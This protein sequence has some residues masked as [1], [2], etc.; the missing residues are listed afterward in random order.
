MLV[1][2]GGL[3][4]TGKTT[5]A[6]EVAR[7]Q[8]ALYLRID[9]IEQ[10]IRAGNVAGGEIGVAGYAV[11]LALAQENLSVGQV[12]VADGVNPVPETRDAWRNI[13]AKRSTRLIE[14]EIVCSDAREHRRRVEARRAAWN[15]GRNTVGDAV[16][17]TRHAAGDAARDA[18]GGAPRDTMGGAT[19]DAIGETAR[20]TIAAAARDA[21][22]AAAQD[23]IGEA[24]RDTIGGAV[25]D[26]VGGAARVAAGDAATVC[27]APPIWDEV[28]S[29]YVP[30]NEDHWVID[31][32]L[33]TA[34]EAVAAICARMSAPIRVES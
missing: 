17:A 1:V 4:G 5:I 11:A 14:I 6:R 27:L 25:R 21:A 2:F 9:T 18:I 34:D 31:T 24:V 8:G 19:P 13:A 20:D 28:L 30:W 7:R 12:V 10:S 23:A 22:G 32:A 16:G 26:A 3:P 33:S 29:H 15:A